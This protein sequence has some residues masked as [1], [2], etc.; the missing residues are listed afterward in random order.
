[1]QLELRLSHAEASTL[2]DHQQQQSSLTLPLFSLFS[3][4]KESAHPHLS[5]APPVPS[6]PTQG[7]DPSLQTDP[8]FGS[9]NSSDL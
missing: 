3:H 2:Q 9:F 8:V 6:L 1:M 5:P 4:A 7:E